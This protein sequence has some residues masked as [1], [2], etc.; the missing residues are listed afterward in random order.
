MIDEHKDLRENHRRAGLE[1]LSVVRTHITARP[2][3]PQ[4]IK[5]NIVIKNS[6]KSRPNKNYSEIVDEFGARSN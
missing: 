3:V 1:A 5:S 6:K 2:L 4:T